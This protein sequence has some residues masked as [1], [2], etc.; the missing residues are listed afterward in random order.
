MRA[1]LPH[2]TVG[3]TLMAIVSL[4]AI[5]RQ[6]AAEK[7]RD[8]ERDQKE[9]ASW[10]VG[11]FVARD[12]DSFLD[13]RSATSITIEG[14]PDPA[15]QIVD[16]FE[17]PFDHHTSQRIKEKIRMRSL[18]GSEISEDFIDRRVNVVAVTATF[19]TFEIDGD[20]IV[21][22]RWR[23]LPEFTQAMRGRAFDDPILVP[24]TAIE[25]EPGCTIAFR[26]EG[27]V[28]VG[29]PSGVPCGPYPKKPIQFAERRMVVGRDHVELETLYVGKSDLDP[30]P[31]AHSSAVYRT[32]YFNVRVAN[33]RDINLGM[34]RYSETEI[35]D[36]G[37]RATIG[38]TDGPGGQNP[39]PFGFNAPAVQIQLKRDG[40]V[41][42]LRVV[43]LWPD[44]GR[45]EL[46]VESRLPA[47]TLEAAVMVRG[48]RIDLRAQRHQV[49]LEARDSSPTL[50][51]RELVAW[52]SGSFS[53][54][55]QEN[56]NPR[57]EKTLQCAP[58]WPIENWSWLYC[59]LGRSNNPD[60]TPVLQWL[61]KLE[62]STSPW[63]AQL[64]FYE[65]KSPA[66]F[67]G[68]WSDPAAFGEIRPSTLT[69]PGCQVELRRQGEGWTGRSTGYCFGDPPQRVD[70][71]LESDRML[72]R[73][74]AVD[75]LDS[76]L[77]PRTTLHLDR[78]D[79]Q[80]TLP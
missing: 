28:F 2:R 43:G 80:A 56:G 70:M 64:I 3:L 51:H 6:A 37:G 77:E 12:P 5:H 7:P 62:R 50:R 15:V 8:L 59:E 68:A 33:R 14:I 72:L 52:L 65:L 13:I 29:T 48:A 69:G 67:A 34:G 78:I 32:T 47:S 20:L 79:S 23:R 41:R 54:L 53:T 66:D 39:D 45:S 30:T 61:A 55:R 76:P 58:I 36:Q 27:D 60:Q 40:N 16:R 49:P 19:F 1:S 10:F 74:I 17:D 18:D 57:S 4:V 38:P 63:S 22:K 21:A 75:T 46:V 35:H 31:A 11:E 25:P 24:R 26:R 42:I 71:R 44:E 73:R 9:L